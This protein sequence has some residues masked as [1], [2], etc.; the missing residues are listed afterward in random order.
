M[1]SKALVTL[2]VF[3]LIV[4]CGKK[5]AEVAQETPVETKPAE[6]ATQT[7]PAAVTT[8]GIPKV[9]GDTVTT[10]SGLKYIEMTLGTGAQPTMSQVV[11]FQYTGWLTD[12]TEF[13]SSRRKGAPL[14]YP[15]SQLAKGVGEGLASMKIGGRR[16]LIIPSNLGYGEK[17]MPG[18]IPPNAT[19]VFDVELV[20]VQ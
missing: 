13:D 7:E 5:E 1:K 9:A 12:G 20:G 10:A 2:A 4:G 15:I 11:T 3:M 17:G 6:Q 8:E 19:L 18:F 14:V 16:L